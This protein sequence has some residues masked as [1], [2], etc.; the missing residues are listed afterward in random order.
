M[1]LP[2][3]WLFSVVSVRKHL[4][5][6]TYLIY[7][8]D[9]CA[10]GGIR[11]WCRNRCRREA[12]V[13]AEAPS[14][15]RRKSCSERECWDASRTWRPATKRPRLVEPEP[16]VASRPTLVEKKTWK[17]CSV[18]LILY[19]NLL[20]FYLVIS[21]SGIWELV[22][23]KFKINWSEFGEWKWHYEWLWPPPLFPI[24]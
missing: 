21:L 4:A 22:L 2:K 13:S 3:R 5:L 6:F 23:F 1:T 9:H 16:R 12:L 17:C 18:V 10:Y 8:V 19:Q 20:T 15:R 7:E 14:W 11:S 24:E